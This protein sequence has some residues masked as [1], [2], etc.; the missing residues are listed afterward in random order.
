MVLW[1]LFFFSANFKGTPSISEQR[2]MKTGIW[3]FKSGS[4]WR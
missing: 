1:V 4:Y 2:T 3:P